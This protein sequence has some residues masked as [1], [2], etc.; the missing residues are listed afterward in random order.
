M[1]DKIRNEESDIHY[2]PLGKG[3]KD[4][5]YL[6]ADRVTICSVEAQ[7]KRFMRNYR[8]LILKKNVISITPACIL[9]DIWGF[10]RSKFVSVYC[11]L[12]PCVSPHLLK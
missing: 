6:S 1:D 3:K 9:Y 7:N 12:G 8:S 11:T 5:L 2:R 10:F 4:C